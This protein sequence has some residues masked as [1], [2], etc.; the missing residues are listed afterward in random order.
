VVDRENAGGAAENGA[1][2][3]HQADGT[4]A[5]HGDAVSGLETRPAECRPAGGQNVTDG[6]KALL[7]GRV[8]LVQWNGQGYQVGVRGGDTGVLS[9]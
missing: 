4:G 3:S 2:G 1:V 9:C 5:E 7:Q 6:D 8:G